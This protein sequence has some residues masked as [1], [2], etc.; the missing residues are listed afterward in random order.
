MIVVQ[1]ETD[2]I[3]SLKPGRLHP[4]GPQYAM[5]ANRARY[6]T[7]AQPSELTPVV[8]PSRLKV[9]IDV[10]MQC[11]FVSTPSPV[12]HLSRNWGGHRIGHKIRDQ[13]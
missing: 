3:R 6:W 2:A 8:V 11:E 9:F 5:R 13:R 12:S 4:P 1:I 7:I 10:R